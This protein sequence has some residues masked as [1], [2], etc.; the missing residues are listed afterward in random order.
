ML[1]EVDARYT[2]GGDEVSLYMDTDAQV[3][4]VCLQGFKPYSCLT[5][6]KALEVWR[7]PYTYIA[8]AASGEYEVSMPLE[9]HHSPPNGTEG[10]NPVYE[11]SELLRALRGLLMA[12]EDADYLWTVAR[13]SDLIKEV[14]REKYSNRPQEYKPYD[15][16]EPEIPF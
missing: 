2:A 8:C 11:S 9:G 14:H 5:R 7:W 10:D 13:I 15:Q 3:Y 12:L 1:T 16:D 6:D 4:L